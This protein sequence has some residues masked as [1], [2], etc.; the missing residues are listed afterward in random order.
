MSAE[1]LL[2]LLHTRGQRIYGGEAV[3]QLEHAL[4]CATLAAEAGEPD[5]VV[6]AALLHD[7]GHL[8]EPDPGSAEAQRVDHR[9]QAT[10][11][12]ALL[13]LVPARVAACVR[14]H[15]DAKR[16]L[17]HADPAYRASLSTASVRSL[18]LQGGPFDAREAQSFIALPFA[19]DAVRVRRYDDRA[20]IAGA[21]TPPLESFASLLRAIWTLPS[22]QSG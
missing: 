4:Q 3:S 5:E 19:E 16:W 9:H 18:A 7:V 14:L 12:Q 22:G 1:D 8:L 20:K 17:C 6:A 11:A 15:V 2:E 13:G 10:G 21:A